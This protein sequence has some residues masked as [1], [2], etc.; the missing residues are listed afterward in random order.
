ML[1]LLSQNQSENI[2][3]NSTICSNSDT[4]IPETLP[5]SII[6]V[7]ADSG[8]GPSRLIESIY[9]IPS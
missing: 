6:F 7:K 8:L 1:E 4:L 2:F 5:D 3:I 9:E